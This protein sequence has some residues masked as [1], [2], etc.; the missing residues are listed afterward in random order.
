MAEHTALTTAGLRGKVVLVQFWTYTCINWLRTLPYVRAWAEA[1]G[2]TWPG[3]DRRAHARVLVRARHRQRAPAARDMRVEYPIAID[4]DYAVW[5]AFS[6]NYWPAL[7]FVDAEGLIRHHQF[8]EGD[9]A[10]SER[11]IQELLAD[12]GTSGDRVPASVDARGAEVPADWDSLESP[13]TY[14]GYA[15]A[16]RFASPGG[17]AYD[18]RRAY[19]IPERLSSIIGRWA[20]TGQWSERPRSS[21]RPVDASRSTSTRA[22]CISSSRQ[23]HATYRCD[24]E[25]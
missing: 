13:E 25:C 1:Y 9:Y 2:T 24:S 8:G 18:E 22:T 11:I 14:V 20:A 6:N 19:T 21:T 12:A 16:E 10:N 17:I 4:N 5:Q 3:R 23:E 7:Y 15:R